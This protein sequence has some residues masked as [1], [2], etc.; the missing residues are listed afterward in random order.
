MMAIS[1]S[2]SKFDDIS[3][4][5]TSRFISTMTALSSNADGLMNAADGVK[6]IADAINS[7]DVTKADSMSKFFGAA[8]EYS[9]SSESGAME[10]LIETV[11]EIRDSINSLG[12]SSIQVEGTAAAVGGGSDNKSLTEYLA[13]LQATLSQINATMSNLPADI[14][15]I[16]IRLPQD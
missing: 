8:A 9:K 1:K 12:Q 6:A 2:V 5:S 7:V 14:A 13:R 10:S 4:N 11:A 15:A 16:E 3:K